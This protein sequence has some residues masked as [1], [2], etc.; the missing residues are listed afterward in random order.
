MISKEHRIQHIE[1]LS[2]RLVYYVFAVLMA[3]LCTVK[4]HALEIRSRHLGIQDGLPNNSIRDFYQDKKGFLWISTLNGLTRYDGN[5]FVNYKPSEG[6]E[7]GLG[8][9]RIRSVRE[10]KNGFLWINTYSKHFSCYDLERGRFVDYTGRGLMRKL[11]YNKMIEVGN[12]VWLYGNSDG[13]MRVVFKDGKFTSNVYSKKNGRLSTNE[14]F[15]IIHGEGDD[16]YI[17]SASG[18][19]HWHKGKAT[20]LSANLHFATDFK[21]G[22]DLFILDTRGGV[23]VADKS[24]R[25][26]VKI[27]NMSLDK[28]TGNIRGAITVAD[29]CVAYTSGP[30]FAFDL[31]TRKPCA[32]PKELDFRDAKV[33]VDNKKNYW[34]KNATGLLRYIN[35]RTGRIKT[36]DL[37]PK[38]NPDFLIREHY[39]IIEDTHGIIWIATFGNGLFTYDPTTDQLQHYLAEDSGS[40]IAGSN[41]LQTIKEDRT[42]SIWISSEFSG[43]YHISVVNKNAL[44]LFPEGTNN[45]NIN[46]IR[47]LKL[48]DGYVWIG[49]RRGSFFRYDTSLHERTL[50][51]QQSKTVYSVMRD[52]QGVLW[53]GTRYNGLFVNG[54]QY[55]NNP[56]DKNSIGTNSIYSFIQDR[57]GRVWIATFGGGLDLAVKGEK[58]YTFRHILRGK[59]EQRFVRCLIM[60]NRGYIWAGT[61]GGL[62][63]F[64]PD[65]ILVDRNHYHSYT[66]ANGALACNEIRS[67]MQDSHGRIY[68]AESGTGFAVC[69][70]KNYNDLRFTHYNTATGLVNSMVQAFAEDHSGRIW[71]STEYGI[72][73]FDPRTAA[74][75]NYFFSDN[76]L[77]DVYCENSAITLPDGRLAF[78]SNHGLVVV[79]P[80]R[81]RRAYNVPTVT[82]TNM[83][84]NGTEVTPGSDDS[85]LSM[86]LAYVKE[87][88]LEHNQNSFEIEFST[89]DFSDEAVVK[90]SYMLENYD[91]EWSKPSIL[92]FAAY[93]NLSSGTYLLHVKTCNAAGKWSENEAVLKVIV[94][95]PWYLTWWAYL[96]Y[97]ITLAAAG[98][99]IVRNTR[100]INDLRNRIKVEKQLTE[101]KLMFF[102]NISHEFRT[103]LTLIQ[104]ALERIENT[105][106]VPR[107]MA[108]SVSIMQR[109]TTRLLRMVNQLI[110]FRK[111]QAGKQTLTLEQTDIIAMLYDIY[112]DFEEVAKDKRITYEFNSPELAYTMFVDRGKI[113]KAVYNLLSNAMK[114]SSEGG[115]VSLE[116]SID[117]M[118]YLLTIKVRDNGIGVPLEKRA[119]LFTRFMQLNTSGNSMGIGLHL[120][121]ELIQTHKGTVSYEENP[122]GGSVFIIKLPTDAS[123]Y[124][125]EDFLQTVE[126]QQE[127]A[128]EESVTTIQTT[129][130]ATKN[131]SEGEDEEATIAPLNNQRV[132]VIEDDRDVREFLAQSLSPYFTIITA[133]DGLKGLEK[134][135]SDAPDLIVSDVLMPGCS[136]FEVVKRLKNN[137]ATSHIPVILVTALS[138]P[139]KQLEGVESGADTYITKP[140]SLKFLLANIQK[141]LLQRQKLREKFTLDPNATHSTISVTTLDKEFADRLKLLIENMLTD[142]KLS[143]DELA[144]RMNMGR[145]TF[146][147][148]VRGVTGYSPNEYIRITKLKK[149]ALMLR[150]NPAKNVAE[151]SYAVGI[152]DPFYFSR[153]FKKQFGVSPSAYQK[154]KNQDG[155][156]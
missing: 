109:S 113:D 128:D 21:H 136:G 88:R 137:F 107:S 50:M 69:T 70:P 55:V 63:V 83:K 64:N 84:V 27:G 32:V 39:S 44:R 46:I 154:G 33:S 98:Y 117:S 15:K 85:P 106:N 102:T 129:E 94:R 66:K 76:T 103:P 155:T 8:D 4:T 68:V 54:I 143:V 3:L 38:G 37:M 26:I 19:Y 89:L 152:N 73:C 52:K 119:Q 57:K 71:V 125:P 78:G 116:V 144:A 16:V 77:G 22:G 67:L 9:H 126:K 112:K 34:V 96:L 134:A 150:G 43:I 60:D 31:K 130:T 104:G 132:L 101:Y 153:M 5:S 7:P 120:T 105:R 118:S 156:V 40:P 95:A 49:T 151:V 121:R 75:D 115:R 146:Y 61:S 30:A 41:F 18:M 108:Y 28:S 131:A 87:V 74:F 135:Q 100:R 123:K 91:N 86:S 99:A 58:G 145:S 47:M 10:D 80:E 24:K 90:Y 48:D 142:P 13:C 6:S 2:T 1:G 93:K 133:S 14:V 114:Y 111:I 56:V 35:S 92:N 29:V 53:V 65:E 127:M 20:L 59:E 138:T 72:S 51:P 97:L 36:F 110:E 11:E 42:G 82:F 139:E 79:N 81:M 12:A 45:S 124:M 147:A 122:G 25:S 23:W 148:K 17:A 140:F 149:A 62:I 141:L